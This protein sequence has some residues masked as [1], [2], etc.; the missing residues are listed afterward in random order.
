MWAKHL[1]RTIEKNRNE[2]LGLL[3]RRHPPFVFSDGVDASIG[4]PAFHFHDVSADCLEPM[5]RFLFDNGYATLTADEYAQR[6]RLG[7]QGLRREVLLTFDD[8][9]RSLYT[10]AYPAL[11][12]YGLKAVA[13]IVPGR[14]PEG[15][16]SEAT[17][18]WGRSL[19][20][21]QEIQEMHESGL[22]DFQSHSMYHHSIAIS[23]RVVEFVRPYL[24]LSFLTSDLAPLALDEGP[25]KRPDELA[26]GTPIHNW[27]ARFGDAQGFGESAAA[28]CACVEHVAR[29]GGVNYF[30]AADW[31][32]R[33]KTVLEMARVKDSAAR[34]E[35][36]ADQRL[37]ILKDFL[38]SKHE[39]ERWL[40]GKTV[41]HFCY[42]WYRGSALAAEL[43]AQAGYISNAWG[44]LLPS[45]VRKHRFPIP[46]A[47]LSSIYIWRLPGKG[48]RAISSILL[49]RVSD[50]F[51]NRQ[52][53]QEY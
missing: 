48:R 17:E 20:N 29:H 5:L 18:V 31:R 6:Q 33:L 13:Y 22:V 38:D 24:N 41:L 44:S 15:D 7:E 21:W 14:T 23:D 47:R 12:R 9:L 46:V 1:R 36:R 11:K 37:A 27:G 34:F 50:K 42:P 40:P 28:I 49:R 10:V 16:G 51:C 32:R 4:V 26:Y 2:V 35:T 3:F 8:G 43:S 25:V 45:F 19:C 30:R 53:N 52:H 39:I